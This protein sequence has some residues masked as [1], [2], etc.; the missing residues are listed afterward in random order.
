MKTHA[1][2]PV[3]LPHIGCPNDC[4]FCNQKTITAK[5]KPVEEQD[6][7]NTIE[8]Y[9]STLL[10]RNMKTIE[11]AFF[12][13]SFTGMPIE[14]QKKYLQIA[15]GYKDKGLINEI[16][17]STRPDYI[18]DEILTHLKH[19]EVNT[20]E[21]GVQ[22][23][24]EEVLKLSNRGHNSDIVKKSADMIHAYGFKLGIQ[25][26]IGLPGDSYEKSIRSAQ[27]AVELKPEVARL[28]PTMVLKD[29]ELENM[30]HKGVYKPFTKEDVLKTTKEMYLILTNAGIK[31]IRIGLKSS[32]YIN[33]DNSVVAGDYHPAFRQVVESEIV[34]DY[35]ESRLTKD[36]EKAIFYSNSTSFSTMI[37]NKKS[38]KDYFEKRYP[39]KKFEFKMNEDLKD[40]EYR[41]E[42]LK[43]LG[44]LY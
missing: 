43:T 33:E 42:V 13:G 32:D 3:F 39:H 16:R 29:T 15:K 17:L 30:Y 5:L 14:D 19:Y 4:V 27:K 38:N 1:N 36:F 26:M 8:T 28:Y 9:L 37:G 31:V 23:F 6:I 44:L 18:D 24:D 7:I 12:G 22:S 20:I 11:I 10:K 40:E 35:L 41:V 2:I 25:L 34:K 21:L